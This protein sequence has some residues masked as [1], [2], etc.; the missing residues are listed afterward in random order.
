MHRKNNICQIGA[1][2]QTKE[3]IRHEE[4]IYGNYFGL[5]HG[6]RYVRISVSGNADAG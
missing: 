1:A 5:R 4:T 3:M 2:Y 6:D